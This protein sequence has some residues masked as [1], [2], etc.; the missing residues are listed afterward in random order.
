MEK[1]FT[2][3]KLVHGGLGLS[4]TE[5]GI[6]FVSDVLPGETVR[7]GCAGD[8]LVNVNVNVNTNL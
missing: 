6:V 4:R 1:I 7:C 5:K 2:I 8:G 3:E